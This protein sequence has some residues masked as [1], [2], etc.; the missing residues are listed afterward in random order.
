MMDPF[1]CTL[2]GDDSDQTSFAHGGEGGPDDPVTTDLEQQLQGDDEQGEEAKAADEESAAGEPTLDAETAE[3]TSEEEAVIEEASVEEVDSA[4]T[5]GEEPAAAEEV[6]EVPAEAEPDPKPAKSPASKIRKDPADEK[7]FEWYVIKVANGREDTLSRKVEKTLSLRGLDG[8][9]RNIVVPKQ[10][11]TEIKEGKKKIR[12][13]KL[14]QGYFFMECQL[15]EDIW[16]LLRDIQGVGSFVGGVGN[17][18]MP[19][20]PDE[21]RKLRDMIEQRES[22]APPEL[23]IDVKKN[24]TVKVKEGPFEN[25]EGV[26]EEVHPKTGKLRVTVTI[27][28]RETPVD[29]EYWQVEQT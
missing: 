24:D 18:P 17:M 2:S 4:E 8:Y 29:L 6:E 13:I 21:V 12:E 10:K 28:G 5:P 25:F 20:T 16:Y 27:F 23:K 11:V 19:M 14:Y 3:D 9:V 7:P 1:L 15:V 22:E 26:V